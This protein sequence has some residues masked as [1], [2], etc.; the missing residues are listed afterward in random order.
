MEEQ[1][2]LTGDVFD[3]RYSSADGDLLFLMEDSIHR[4][5]ISLKEIAECLKVAEENLEIEPLP[6]GFW[7]QMYNR[8]PDMYKGENYDEEVQTAQNGFEGLSD[9][10][11]E[12]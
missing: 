3:T 5:T 1:A 12:L 4:F 7:N 2:K 6:Q 11:G 10:E 8:Y 9:N